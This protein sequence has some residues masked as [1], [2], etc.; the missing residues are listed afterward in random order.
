M[1]KLALYV[2]DGKIVKINQISLGFDTF[3]LEG[4]AIK[5]MFLTYEEVKEIVE[6]RL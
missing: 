3:N 2:V 5:P 6:T 1:Y 4:E